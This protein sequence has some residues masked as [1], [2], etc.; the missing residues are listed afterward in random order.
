VKAHANWRCNR[1]F[2]FNGLKL[3]DPRPKAEPRTCQVDAGNSLP[4]YCHAFDH[5]TRGGRR[6]AKVQL[7]SRHDLRED[8]L[9]VLSHLFR[10]DRVI[11][12]HLV[13]LSRL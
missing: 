11:R 8:H 7:R 12:L 6:Q 3:P 2:S 13:A 4:R 5:R 10:V 9:S 1:E